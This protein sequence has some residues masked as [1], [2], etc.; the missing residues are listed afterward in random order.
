MIDN[1]FAYKSYHSDPSQQLINS[2]HRLLGGR[3]KG[4]F[5][6]SG[7]SGVNFC[8]SSKALGDLTSKM[9]GKKINVMIDS[10]VRKQI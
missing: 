8:E 6:G 7:L 2:S 1:F 3:G 10:L 9:I 5:I 4:A